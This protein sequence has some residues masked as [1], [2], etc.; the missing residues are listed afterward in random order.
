MRAGQAVE[1]T[2]NVMNSNQD[3]PVIPVTGF[4]MSAEGQAFVFT[5]KG[6]E[7]HQQFVQLGAISDL[8]VEVL[9]GLADGEVIVTKGVDLLNDRQVVNPIDHS[10]NQYGL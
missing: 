10:H 8:G 3:V 6:N 5:V 7:V 2:V 4:G 9:S 1:V